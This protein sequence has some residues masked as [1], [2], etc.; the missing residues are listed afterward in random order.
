MAGKFWGIQFSQK[1]HLQ[2]FHDLIFANGRSRTAPPTI[3]H[4]CMPTIMVT[5]SC[6]SHLCRPLR[7]LLFRGFNFHG[8]LLNCENRKNWIPRKFPAIR[9]F[10][11]LFRKSCNSQ[12]LESHNQNPTYSIIIH[13]HIV[14]ALP[15]DWP[16]FWPF[17][18]YHTQWQSWWFL[19][20]RG[21][22]SQSRGGLCLLLWH[23]QTWTDANRR[24]DR[25]LNNSRC[26][27]A[28]H[29]PCSLQRKN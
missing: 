9:Y 23:P 16:W 29:D 22:G 13:N 25:R 15:T 7:G 3:Q 11:I 12:S 5:P 8:L 2:R 14:Y 1:G 26:T 17:L 6:W 10:A 19:D 21:W 4:A 20:S 24:H 18:C 27:E 28:R